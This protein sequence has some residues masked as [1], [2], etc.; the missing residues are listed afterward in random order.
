M[1]NFFLAPFR[2]AHQMLTNP[3]KSI[4][5]NDGSFILA[6]KKINNAIKGEGGG[7]GEVVRD[8]W[9]IV[10][11]NPERM[12]EAE[13]ERLKSA[14]SRGSTAR[15]IMNSDGAAA[16]AFGDSL[17]TAWEIDEL[18]KQSEQQKKTEEQQQKEFELMLERFDN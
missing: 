17:K 12:K 11:M 2:S 16:H 9:R 18:T 14:V 13:R 5:A 3:K 8:M 6:A 4:S 7:W 10:T 15:N 1:G